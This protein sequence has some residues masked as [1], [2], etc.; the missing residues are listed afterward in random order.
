MESG[1]LYLRKSL[2]NFRN[3]ERLE[4]RTVGRTLYVCVA[5][6]GASGTKAGCHDPVGQVSDHHT[7]VYAIHVQQEE[8]RAHPA[9]GIVL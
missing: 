8:L 6:S 3:W 1:S 5:E 7:S 2:S 9:A 4:H